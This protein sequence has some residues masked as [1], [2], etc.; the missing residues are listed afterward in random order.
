[1]FYRNRKRPKDVR[2]KLDLTKRRYGILKNAVD[3]AKEHQ[4]LDYIFADVNCCLT[5]GFKDGTFNFFNDINNLKSMIIAI[6]LCIQG[7]SNPWDYITM[8]R[9]LWLLKV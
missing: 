7:K 8:A 2:I 3:L 4:G 9:D 6:Y 5:V 1:M